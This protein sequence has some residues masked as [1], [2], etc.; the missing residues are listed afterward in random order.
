M[1]RVSIALGKLKRS[2]TSKSVDGD[3][4]SSSKT[5]SDALEVWKEVIASGWLVKTGGKGHTVKNSKRRWFV[6]R[7]V[8]LSY[9]TE[10]P[11]KSVF[12]DREIL[13][14]YSI[15]NTLG[16]REL[17][18]PHC[19]QKVNCISLG[20]RCPKSWPKEPTLPVSCS[21]AEEGKNSSYLRQKIQK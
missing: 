7:G 20:L 17:T 16:S 1:Q 9:Y 14:A 12:K 3:P 13:S 4:T 21:Q 8:F 19:M 10:D 2:R 18:P 11:S 5:G 6:L 15:R